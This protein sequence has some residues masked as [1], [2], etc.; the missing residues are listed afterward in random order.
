[1]QKKTGNNKYKKITISFTE[2]DKD[3]V[4]HIEELKKSN[5]A[6]EFIREAIREKINNDKKEYANNNSFII[7]KIN[8]L[9][10]K[11]NTMENLLLENHSNL[12]QEQENTTSN[13]EKTNF[14]NS[15]NTKPKQNIEQIDEDI[16]NAL[17]FFDF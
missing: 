5:K 3:I 12:P 13:K 7:E 14:A 16:E 2:A 10:K 9:D 17:D 6:S 11:I 8:N 15:N 4:K 1:M